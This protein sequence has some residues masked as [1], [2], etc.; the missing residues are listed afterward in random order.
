MYR[1]TFF[2]FLYLSHDYLNTRQPHYFNYRELTF[3]RL[4]FSQF[5]LS[6]GIKLLQW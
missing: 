2:V 6:F 4:T 3:I 1:I 5:N